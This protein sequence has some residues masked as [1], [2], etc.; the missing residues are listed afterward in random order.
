[1]KIHHLNCGT[2]CTRAIPYLMDSTRLCTH[3]LL[4]ESSEGLIAVDS[5][6]SVRELLR[7][8][9][10][11]QLQHKIFSKYPT[12]REALFNQIAGLGFKPRDVRHFVITHLDSDHAGGLLDFPEAQVHLY[13]TEYERALTLAKTNPIFAYRLR[14]MDWNTSKKWN[15]YETAGDTWEGFECIRPLK[16]IK[17]D[18]G[19]VPL[20]GH[21]PG[22]AGVLINSERTILHVGDL[23]YHSSE[24]SSVNNNYAKLSKALAYNNEARLKNLRR[25]VELKE[26]KTTEIQFI[27]SHDHDQWEVLHHHSG[28][29]NP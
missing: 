14:S 12:P 3:C 22:H 16:G 15:L 2:Y 5:G 20:I 19:I 9:L 24:L 23:Y 29:G 8:D 26:K 1:M 17:A 10:G 25:I 27:S 6:S 7:R 21:T 28:D 11:A 4:I 18:L 13:K